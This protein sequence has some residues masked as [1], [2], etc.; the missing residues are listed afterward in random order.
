[1]VIFSSKVKVKGIRIRIKKKKK[2]YIKTYQIKYKR[3]NNK[4]KMHS[5]MHKS[6]S[7][8]DLIVHEIQMES[9]T[10]APVWTQGMCRV[11]TFP[12]SLMEMG[13]GPGIEVDLVTT[14]GV[15]D[16]KQE[17][18]K[19]KERDNDD[20]D[21]KELAACLACPPENTTRPEHTPRLSPKTLDLFVER[22]NRRRRRSTQKINVPLL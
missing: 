8:P 9:M 2:T 4:R 17:K 22:R 21:L 7:M 20:E 18:T 14:K 12:K 19:E 6:I 15:L 1:M 3:L 11:Q 13:T 10:R 5:L 16:L